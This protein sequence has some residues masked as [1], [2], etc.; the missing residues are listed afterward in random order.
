MAQQANWVKGSNWPV[1]PE[2]GL[3][4]RNGENIAR[5]R[6]SRGFHGI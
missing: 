4:G 1:E 6:E 2:A 5:D 3:P